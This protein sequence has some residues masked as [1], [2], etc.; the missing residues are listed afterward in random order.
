MTTHARKPIVAPELVHADPLVAL[1][2]PRRRQIL[3]LLEHPVLAG[4]L[5]AR[6]HDL[7][8][9]AISAHLAILR[10]AGLVTCWAEGTRRWYQTDQAALEAALATI[11]REV[12]VDA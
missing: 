12:G 2:A 7:S 11:A 3:R 4:D 8:R 5:A 1:A 9:P 6:I 10:R